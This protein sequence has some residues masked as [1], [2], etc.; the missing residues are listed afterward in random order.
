MNNRALHPYYLQ[1][2]GIEPWVLRPKDRVA[3]V[4]VMVVGGALDLN[5]RLLLNMFKSIA[6]SLDDVNLLPVENTSTLDLCKQK[7]LDVAPQVLLVMGQFNAVDSSH[8]HG[9]PLFVIDPSDKKS[10]YRDL[11]KAQQILVTC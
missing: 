5:G 4:K 7:I 10:A 9:I 6:L 11:L 8:Y 3:R 2:M 1:Q